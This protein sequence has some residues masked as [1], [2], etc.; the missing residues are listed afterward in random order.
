MKI[1]KLFMIDFL[2]LLLNFFIL[3]GTDFL[4]VLNLYFG[5]SKFLMTLIDFLK[6]Y[7]ILILYRDNLF[8]L[9]QLKYVL[10]K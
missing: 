7:Y 1:L 5:L 10:N 8:L 6:L 4:L 2:L 9:N 3:Y